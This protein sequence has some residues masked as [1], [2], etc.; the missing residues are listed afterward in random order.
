MK[1]S[2]PAWSIFGRKSY[3]HTEAVP[4]PGA[5][6]PTSYVLDMGPNFGFGR[7]ARPALVGKQG[8]P[9]PGSYMPRAVT[10]SA[11]RPIFG[12]SNRLPLNGMSDTPGPGSYEVRPKSEGPSYSLYGRVRKEKRDNSPGPGHYNPKLSTV[13]NLPAPRMGT[14]KRGGEITYSTFPGP[15][16]YPMRST[17]EGPKWGLG[18]G[19]RSNMKPQN[20]PGPGS[21]ELKSTIS[22]LPSY[23]QS[24]VHN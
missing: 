18:S 11:R 7:S 6:N 4:G 19:G 2:A 17:L 15:G 8:S 21:Y 20:T 9:G 16:S 3:K 10:P 5:Y 12:R 23:S 24:S 1:T 13:D 22:N 14:A